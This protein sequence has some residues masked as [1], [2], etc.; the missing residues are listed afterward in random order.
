M[1]NRRPALRAVPSREDGSTSGAVKP[2]P[3][4][5]LVFIFALLMA[6]TLT[7]LVRRYALGRGLMDHPNARSS[8]VRPT[9]RGGGLGIVASFLAGS[10]ALVSLGLASK[11]ALTILAGPSILVATI[12]LIDDVRSVSA[13]SRFLVHSGAAVLALYAMNGPAPFP[14]LGHSVDLGWLAPPLALLYLVWVT[15]LYNFMDGLDGIAG[16][17]G[18]TVA[19]G[20]ALCWWLATGT[21]QW[22]VPALFAACVAGFLIWNLPPAKIFLGDVGSG[23]IGSVLGALSLWSAQEAGQVFW[24]WSILLGCFMVDATVTLLRRVAR[25]ERFYEAHRSHAYQYAARVH[26]SHRLVSASIG[27]INLIWLLPLACAVAVG[28]LD[29]AV[30]LLVAYSPLV[31]VAFRYKAGDRKS[32]GSPTAGRS[33]E[34]S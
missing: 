30:G 21:P 28:K 9:P 34:E 29:G 32:Q 22:H 15:N 17:E 27:A 24:C 11:E 19:I 18:V 20:G 10:A 2:L 25:G 31:W 16:I 1:D 7:A 12:G 6:W 8:H 23:F 26:G 3:M 33:M 4:T 14:L 13:R 5:T